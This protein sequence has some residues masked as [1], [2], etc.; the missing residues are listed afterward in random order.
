MNP[1]IYIVSILSSVFLI[2]GCTN[3]ANEAQKVNR[4]S[5][6]LILT[7]E[8]LKNA[9]VSTTHP[10]KMEIKEILKVNGKIEAPPQNL[11]SISAPLGGFLRS[12]KLM[13]GMHIKKGE[14][15]AV[16]E[17]PQ[18]IQLQQDY[19]VS[20]Q[21]AKY[22]EKEY[23]RQ[24]ELNRNQAASDKILQQTEADFR[25]E[26]ITLKSLEEKLRLLGID[27]A[28]LNEHNISR[29]VNINSPIDGF[30]TAVNVNIGKY[31]EPQAV[32]FE[33]VNPED[34]HLS[35]TVFEKDLGKLFIG[36]NVSAY[37]NHDPEKK[38]PCEVI[39][40]GMNLSSDRSVEVHCHFRQYDKSL[41]PGMYMNAD[42]ETKAHNAIVVPEKALIQHEG[43]D[44]IFIS[45]SKSAYIL[46]PVTRGITQGDF[47]E[48]VTPVDT[49]ASIVTDGSYTLLMALKNKSED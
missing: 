16:M 8:Q 14:T 37:T 30:V 6:T 42:I 43:K 33:L 13:P 2:A 11:V 29:T 24:K 40:I 15:I 10:G 9:S 27:P 7:P 3:N 38:Y 5:D 41:I 26:K 19:L 18:Y 39:L 32:L 23:E 44:Y 4:D 35:L 31:V 48:L 36:Q 28:R 34:I 47:T 1:L 17:D 25:S 22:L 49:M 21:K 45:K 20:G 46:T 12:T